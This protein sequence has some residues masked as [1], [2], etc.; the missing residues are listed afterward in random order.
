[1]RLCEF[2][3]LAGVPNLAGGERVLVYLVVIVRTANTTLKLSD[4]QALTM[5][6]MKGG[7]IYRL[8]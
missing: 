6:Q 2:V 7:L 3:Q 1:M 8:L 5:A 4:D